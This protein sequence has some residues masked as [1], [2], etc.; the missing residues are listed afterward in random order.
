MKKRVSV[1]KMPDGRGDPSTWLKYPQPLAN[2]IHRGREK[3]HAEAAHHSV[4]GVRWKGQTINA[5]FKTGIVKAPALC[6]SA[7]GLD[8]RGDQ[9]CAHHLAFRSNPLSDAQGWFT[10]AHGDIQNPGA[11]GDRCIVDE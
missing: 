6:L 10:G 11:L 2:C 7:S 9:I 5:H 1:R 4:E 3:H 8:H